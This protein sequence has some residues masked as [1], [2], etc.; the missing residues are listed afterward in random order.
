MDKVAKKTKVDI[1]GFHQ[2]R[3]EGGHSQFEEASATH[4]TVVVKCTREWVQ[5]LGN[6]TWNQQAH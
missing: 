6:S 4:I 3:P 5:T 2:K 1:V